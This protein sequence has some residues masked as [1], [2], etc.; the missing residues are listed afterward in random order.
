MLVV[1]LL[2]SGQLRSKIMFVKYEVNN[3]SEFHALSINLCS[4]R[5]CSFE[6]YLLVEYVNSPCSWMNFPLKL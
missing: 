2:V 3:N 4:L 5:S 1:F 6:T